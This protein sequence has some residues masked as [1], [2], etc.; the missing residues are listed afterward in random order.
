MAY[1]PIPSGEITTGQPVQSKTLN[2]IKENFESLNDRVGTL[3]GGGSTVYP[4]IIFRVN[5][6]YGDAIDFDVVTQGLGILKTT[7][8]FSI[9]ITG[10]RILIDKAGSSGI[11]ELDLK[12]KRGVSSYT[13]IFNTLPS[14]SYTA[15]DDSISS[16]AVINPSGNTL[17]AG[18]ILRLD[19]TQVQNM[20]KNFI[21]RIDYIKN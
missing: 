6:D 3:E 11:T 18:D 17:E 1:N 21:V 16:N 12:Y 5:G 14:V 7:L 19:L 8:N 20:A 10:V 9:V 13:S 2:T 4:P 15:G